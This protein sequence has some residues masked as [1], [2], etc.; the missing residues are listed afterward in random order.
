MWLNAVE[1]DDERLHLRRRKECA[2]SFLGVPH[3]GIDDRLGLVV[4]HEDL[5]QEAVH[6]LELGTLL[7]RDRRGAF[8]LPGPRVT[9]TQPD[10]SK[11]GA[12]ASDRAQTPAIGDRC[13]PGESAQSAAAY[14]RPRALVTDRRPRARTYA[15][16]LRGG[17][18]RPRLAASGSAPGAGGYRA[19]W[20]VSRVAS[21]ETPQAKRQPASGRRWTTCVDC[22][23]CSRVL[24]KLSEPNSRG[25]RLG[26]CG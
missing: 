24:K 11:Y 8:A 6:A 16:R 25:G 26:G 12:E 13:W 21:K 14:R 18:A 9:M 22:V 15:L 2:G 23:L 19:V 20:V 17:Q 5:A 10:S 3:V 4:P 1:L 7:F